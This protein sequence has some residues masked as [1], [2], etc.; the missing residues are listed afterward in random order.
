MCYLSNSTSY[1]KPDSRPLTSGRCA[2]GACNATSCGLCGHHAPAG[3]TLVVH[4]AND[5]LLEPAH[6]SQLLRVRVLHFPD[7][8]SVTLPLPPSTI[9]AQAGRMIYSEPV[10]SVLRRG[11]CT[12]VV[13]SAARSSP[14]TRGLAP[15]QVSADGGLVIF[16]HFP[17]LNIGSIPPSYPSPAAMKPRKWCPPMLCWAVHVLKRTTVNSEAPDFGITSRPE[18]G[19]SLGIA[20][21]SAMVTAAENSLLLANEED[22]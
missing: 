8:A 17:K 6:T 22:V 20:G 18:V 2:G 19:T 7:G 11:N 5:R 10:G 3:G 13:I 14:R 16:A 21:N 1:D 12:T 15:A 9:P 4:A